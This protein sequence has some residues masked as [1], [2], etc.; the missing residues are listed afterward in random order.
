MRSA[1]AVTAEGAL[2]PGAIETP[3][4]EVAVPV[5]PGGL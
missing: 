5:D 1:N 4:A 3:D 2:L